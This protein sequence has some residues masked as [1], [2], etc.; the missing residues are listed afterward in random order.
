MIKVESISKRY[1]Y[2]AARPYSAREYFTGMLSGGRRQMRELWAL[3]DVSFEVNEGETL[4][5]IGNNGAGKST[6]LKVLS[7]ITKPTSGYAEILGRVGSLLEVGTGF[8]QELSGRENIYLNGAI[9][10]MRRNE[11]E[12]RFDEIVAFSEIEEFLDTP[13]K[14]YSSGMYMRL[15]FAIAAH[16]EPE[17][18]IVDEVLAVGD[19]G[20]QRKCLNKMR[21]VGRSGRTVL[22]VSH[23]MQAITRLC[24]R[25]IWFREGGIVAD[26]ETRHVISDYI[27]E[28]SRTGAERSWDD[29][30]TAPGNASARLRRVRVIGSEGP[31][32]ATIDI[33]K[34]VGIE[35]TFESLGDGKMLV[36]SFQFNNEQGT[37]LFVSHDWTGGRVRQKGVYKSTVWIPG[38]YLAE[39]QIFVTAGMASHAPA[40]THFAARDAVTFTVIDSTEGGTARGDLAGPMPGVVRP[41]LDW[42]TTSGQAGDK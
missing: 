28:Q 37:C 39:G 29:I 2:G 9:L 6:L 19:V 30:E 24:S 10:G 1:F 38:N 23:D 3:R 21:D 42:E 34:R 36:P 31:A 13:V 17:V 40:E 5:I 32:S 27:H 8:H 22:F 12:R 14:H 41:M 4:G 20:F 7:R 35:M 26:G 33:R 11:I 15:A 18:L 16:L 25:V